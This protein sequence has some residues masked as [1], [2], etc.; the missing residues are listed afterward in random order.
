MDFTEAGIV[1]SVRL[2]LHIK[3]LYPMVSNWLPVSNVTE[4]KPTASVFRTRLNALLPI[5]V[6]VL[7][8][9]IALRQPPMLLKEASPISVIGFSK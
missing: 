4:V 8:M 2:E 9:V 5:L 7:G 3:A 6:T 1:I